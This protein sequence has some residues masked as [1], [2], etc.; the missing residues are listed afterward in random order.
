MIFLRFLVILLAVLGLYYVFIYRNLGDPNGLPEAMLYEGLDE[1]PYI[2]YLP[3]HHGA[4]HTAFPLILYLHDYAGSINQGSDQV[5]NQS[6]LFYAASQVDFPFVVCAPMTT[7]QGWDMEKLIVLLDAVEEQFATDPNKIFL[8]G[9]GD[10]ADMVWMMGVFYPQRFAAIAPLAGIGDPQFAQENLLETPVWIFHG[11]RDDIV[12]AE[13]SLK[14]FGALKGKNQNLNFTL[15]PDMG[16][17]IGLE[18]YNQPLLYHWF[19]QC[20]SPEETK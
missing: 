19:L 12:P 20:I 9:I 5:L 14:M 10:G 7:S 4:K 15:Y 8:T 3:V 17:D 1:Y 6:P 18:V 2:A 13:H 11:K 16:H